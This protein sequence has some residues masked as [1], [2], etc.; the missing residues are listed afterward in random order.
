MR[1]RAIPLSISIA[2]LAAQS[3]GLAAPAL[4]VSP[5][6]VP[7]LYTGAEQTW[8]V[9]DGVNTIHVALVGGM[10]GGNATGSG[11][12]GHGATV[13]GDLSVTP[14]D[15][16]YVEVG[17]NGVSGSANDL[18]Q[19]PTFNGGANCGSRSAGHG[20]GGT[21]VRSVA[22]GQAGSLASRLMVAGGG[23]GAGGG[24]SSPPADGGD[25][26]Q[27]GTNAPSPGDPSLSAQGGEAGTAFTG[28]AGGAQ[29]TTGGNGGLSGGFGVGGD[30]GTPGDFGGG[31]GG[32]GWYGGGGGGGGAQSLP[33][34]AGGGGGS[35]FTGA[36]TNASVTGDATGTPFVT[37]SYGATSPAGGTVDATVTMATSALCLSL[38]T[39]SIDFGTRQFGDVG[40]A[41]N[42][43]VTATN[44]GGSGEDVL[45]R[46]SDAS[47]A[48]PTS[49]T[50]DDT[51][52]CAG[53][54]L[55]TDHFG[56]AV[57]RQDTNA[58]VRLSTSN[59]ALETLS[60][61]AAIDHL[62]RIDTPCP[63]GSGAGVVMT[64]HITFVATE[65]VP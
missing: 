45:A 2:A 60:G 28:G 52:T 30:G 41:A 13:T 56:L 21:D 44:C 55:A 54:T 25:A 63:G 4:G 5:T 20:G 14:G 23:G 16:I 61:G 22:A 26:G 43:G 33:Y 32:G 36:A 57:E 62:A 27:P 40:I 64:M 39:G 46:G 8:L 6:S 3:L 24:A 11:V 35:S 58:Q 51:G 38:S 59:K 49:W 34:G 19:T 10:G 50:L 48:G 29:S 1:S 7:F 53:A 31:G 15:T 12:G 18:C 42:P 65:S 17:G 47:G 37:I 9:P